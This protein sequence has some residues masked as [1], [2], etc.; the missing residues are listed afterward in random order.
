MDEELRELLAQAQARFEAM[1]PEEKAAHRQAQR[2]SFM[3]AFAPCEH[4]DYDW[5][6]CPQCLATFAALRNKEAPRGQ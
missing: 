2:E 4:G 1:T 6:T 3:R 5:E